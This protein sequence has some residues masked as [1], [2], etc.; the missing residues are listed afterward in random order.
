[1]ISEPL[2]NN[3]LKNTQFEK[4][5]ISQVYSVG[6]GYSQNV[7]MLGGVGVAAMHHTVQAL[8]RVS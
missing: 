8:S 7:C 2:C 6:E 1:M 5:F 4:P 3:I